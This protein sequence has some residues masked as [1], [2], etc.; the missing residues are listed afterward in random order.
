MTETHKKPRVFVV[1]DKDVIASSLAM[2]LRLQSGF[3]TRSFTNPLDAL[4]AARLETPDLLV[5]DVGMP[6]FSGIDLAILVREQ[7]PRCKVLLYSGQAATAGLLDTAMVSGRDFEVLLQPAHP[8]DLLAEIR[9]LNE[10]IVPV[11]FAGTASM[12]LSRQ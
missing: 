8:A 10:S 5:S 7:C 6:L 11:P 4:E 1:D 9:K 2:I 3:Q 12:M